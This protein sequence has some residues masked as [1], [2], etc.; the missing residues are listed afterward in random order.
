MKNIAENTHNNTAMWLSQYL[1]FCLLL[2]HFACQNSDKDAW[3]TYR[4]DN[5]RSGI[6]S[7]NLNFPLTQKWTH[8]PRH[9]PVTSWHEPAGELPRMHSDNVYH[10]TAANGMAYF[11][12]P[13]DNKVYAIDVATGTTR[14]TFYTE[15]P[16]RF[17]P[18]ILEGQIYVGSDDGYVYCLHAKSGKL[19][20][21]YRPGPSDERILGV[22]RM[23]SLWPVR[24]SILLDDGIAYFAAGIFPYEGLYICALNADDGSVVWSNNSIGDRAHELQY[25]GFSPQSYLVASK[26]VLYVPSGRALPAA[27]DKNTGEF[28]FY[29]NPGDPGKG[30]GTW[31]LLDGD[32]LVAGVDFYG[33]P[34]KLSFNGKTGE[35]I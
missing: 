21:K 9:A 6:T 34:A 12:S 15:G 2:I 14:W 28:L 32:N 11:G 26:D 4:N 5:G 19:L 20:W 33:T 18:T 24:T 22:G 30:G 27:F 29:T 17:A 10:V 16:V 23:I 31:T 3:M 25:G 35:K 7:T 13:T 8:I 1:G